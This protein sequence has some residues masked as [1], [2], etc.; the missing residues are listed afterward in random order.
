MMSALPL[1]RNDDKLNGKEI[2]VCMKQRLFTEILPLYKSKKN[3]PYAM[4]IR[5]RMADRVDAAVLRDAVDTTMKRYPYFC[6]RLREKSGEFVFEDNP[7]PVVLFDSVHGVALNAKNSNY[8]MISFS[9]VDDWIVMDVFHGLTDGTGAYEVIR[10][11]LYYYCSR[12][13]D[14]TLSGQGIRTLEDE[15]SLEEWECPVMKAENLPTP[16]RYE[17][18]TALNPG[19]AANLPVEKYSTVYGITVAENEF[20]QF[21][22]ENGA[23][24]GT[25]VSLLLSRAIA[26]L[27]PD[28][29]EIIRII[30]CV[31]QR[32]ALHAPLAHQSLVGGALLAYEKN[33]RHLSLRQQIQA[34]RNMVA[35]QT[36]EENVLSGVASVVGLTK[37]LLSKNRHE[38][39]TGIAAYVDEMAVRTGTACVSYVGKANFQ[40]AEKYVR[41]F[42]VGSYNTTPITVQI[43]AVNGKFTFDFIQK[44]HSPIYVHAF[45]KELEENGISYEFQTGMREELPHIVL[46]WNQEQ[47]RP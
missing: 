27:F 10:T 30:L 9:Y 41:E 36:T 23:S 34:Y 47:A 40:E 35:D 15:I 7:S 5:M 13:Y 6:V 18:P 19:V 21:N 37:M 39:R 45:L 32:K 26:K 22:R 43:S 29:Q 3:H 2:D 25:M 46:P 16:R 44:F 31:N 38:E 33:L 20:M 17:M 28:A 42:H 11:L 12:R 14:V 4:R 8:H 1:R 24:P